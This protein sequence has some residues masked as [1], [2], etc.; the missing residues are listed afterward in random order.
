ML[1]THMTHEFLKSLRQFFPQPC[2]MF[3]TLYTTLPTD[4]FLPV[5]IKISGGDF[6]RFQLI[7]YQYYRFVLF[8]VFQPRIRMKYSFFFGQWLIHLKSQQRFGQNRIQNI[9][10]EISVNLLL[11]SHK[12]YRFVRIKCTLGPTCA[13]IARWI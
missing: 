10:Q 11:E 1:R 5:S 9:D 3:V 12:C 6:R 2:Q 7:Y 8:P 13:S 4:H